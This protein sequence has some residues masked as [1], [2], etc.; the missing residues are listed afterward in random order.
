MAKHQFKDFLMT[1]DD[2]YKDFVTTVHE[3]LQQFDTKVRIQLSK[4]NGFNVSYSQQPKT[5]WYILSFSF[6]NGELMVRVHPENYAK[7]LDVL[8]NMPKKVVEHINKADICKKLIDPRKC[9]DTCE[10]GY[11]FHIG[12]NHYQ[13]CRYS[14]FK[15]KVDSENIPFLLELIESECKERFSA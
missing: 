3:L 4:A 9:W 1:V 13:K 14:C 10:P 5:T 12:E 8:N 15:L 6:R 7:Y 11:D 2:D